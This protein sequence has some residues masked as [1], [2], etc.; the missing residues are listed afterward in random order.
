M[1][2]QAWQYPGRSKKNKALASGGMVIAFIGPE[3]TGKSTLVSEC[4]HWLGAVFAV[5]A[6][7]AG[8]PPSSRLTTPI[9]IFIPVICRLFPHLRTSC[10]EDHAAFPEAGQSSKQS[11]GLISVIYALRAVTIAWDRRR[12]LIGARRSA[13]NGRIIICDRYPSGE[14]GQMDSPR[15][16]ED[17]ARQGLIGSIYNWLARFEGRLYQEIAPP[18]IALRLNVALDTAIRRNRER[19][20]PGKETDAYLKSRHRESRRW[21]RAGTRYIYDIN[22]EQPLNETILSVKKAIWKSL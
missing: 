22:T 13:G 5:E 18:D 20:K 2:E 8:K 12:L 4:E 7:H 11:T 9:S 15:L 14:V 21:N 1:L 16:R 3:A 10:L 6:I 19:I 17:P